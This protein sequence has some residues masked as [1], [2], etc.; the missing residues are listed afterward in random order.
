MKTINTIII[1]NEMKSM[2]INANEFNKLFRVAYASTS[3]SVQG[4][5]INKPYTI[6]QFNIMDEH[7]K[8]VSLTRATTIDNINIL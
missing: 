2:T 5:S 3:Y 4:M 1:K 6:H 7:H 8:Y